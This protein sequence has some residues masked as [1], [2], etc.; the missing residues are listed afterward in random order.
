[1]LFNGTKAEDLLL[2][3]C[4]QITLQ[5]TDLGSVFIT[6]DKRAAQLP[7]IVSRDVRSD[8]DLLPTLKFLEH[9]NSRA[10]SEL[11]SRVENGGCSSWLNIHDD[12]DY[13]HPMRREP[14]LFTHRKGAIIYEYAC[15]IFQVP[16]AE[17]P[18]CLSGVPVLL[19]GRK[20]MSN[21][22][23]RVLTPHLVTQPCN[24]IYPTMNKSIS[25]GWITVSTRVLQVKTPEQMQIS[26]SYKASE[27]LTT[28]YTQEELHKWEQF[29]QLPTYEKSQHQRL[30]N[31]L[32]NE[33][34]CSYGGHSVLAGMNMEEFKKHIHEG[35]E[36]ML[37]AINPFG[38]IYREIEHLKT[39]LNTMLLLEY[40]VL[41]VSVVISV[42][43]YGC[44]ATL[45]ALIT[46]LTLNWALLKNRKNPRRNPVQMEQLIANTENL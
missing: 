33:D 34:S 42:L 31:A 21:L 41:T 44:T 2:P 26:S 13:L 28:L 24:E 39:F 5:Q 10:L 3:G 7:E 1:M 45:G 15:K 12:K 32:C 18:V 38:G 4:P 8:Q 30:L 19:R 16:V 22:D 37:E 43:L 9:Q 6:F 14:G 36:A 25:S 20:F 46:R 17:A 23:T 40:S 35:S 11:N 27:T 29:L